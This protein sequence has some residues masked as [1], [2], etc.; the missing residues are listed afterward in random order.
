MPLLTPLGPIFPLG[1]SLL[2]LEYWT[3]GATGVYG[4]WVF[5]GDLGLSG[6]V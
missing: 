2:A 5:E 4:F 3:I 1:D 6:K